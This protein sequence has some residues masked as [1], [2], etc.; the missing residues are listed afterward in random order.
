M[1]I[2]FESDP[3]LN[4]RVWT[5][6]EGGNGRAYRAVVLP[7]RMS[8]TEARTYATNRGGSLVNLDEP[9]EAAWVFEN[10]AAFTSLWTQT[11]YNVGPWIGLFLRDGA[12]TWLSDVP[13]DGDGWF[14]GEPNG[15]GDR[16]TYFAQPDFSG[17]FSENFAGTPDGELFGAAQYADVFGNPRLKLVSDGFPGTWGTW[18]TP[19]IPRGLTA[20]SASFRKSSSLN[21][22]AVTSSTMAG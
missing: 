7:R 8:W 2:E 21:N 9:G 17:G 1:L 4:D 5:T 3:M 14:P 13:F 19:P 20:F 10:L 22:P 15:T 12:W 6:A 11:D 16:G 18:K